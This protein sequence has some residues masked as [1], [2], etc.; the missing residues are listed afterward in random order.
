[1]RERSGLDVSEY[2]AVER[3]ARPRRL[4]GVADRGTA[5]GTRRQSRLLWVGANASEISELVDVAI[6]ALLVW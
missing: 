5:P 6:A 3:S 2:L 1:V 4:A